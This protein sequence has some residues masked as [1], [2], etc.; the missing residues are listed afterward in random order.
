MQQEIIISSFA[1]APKIIR[2]S[3]QNRL[4][5]LDPASFLFLSPFVTCLTKGLRWEHMVFTYM[6]IRHTRNESTY[7]RAILPAIFL[8]PVRD[9][10]N[11]I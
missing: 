5:L 7:R 11:K 3:E 9:V 10:P 1:C 4:G 2:L 8:P 6:Y